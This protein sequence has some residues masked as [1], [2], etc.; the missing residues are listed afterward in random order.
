[1]IKKLLAI[2]FAAALPVLAKTPGEVL[3]DM[4]IAMSEHF[5]V[6]YNCNFRYKSLSKDDT[7]SFTCVAAM[8]RDSKDTIIG[9][10]LGYATNNPD[11]LGVIRI[12]DLLNIYK[13][14]PQTKSAIKYFPHKGQ[15]WALMPTNSSYCIYTEFYHPESIVK[16]SDLKAELLSDT[17]IGGENCYHLMFHG[18]TTAGDL[19]NH[20]CVSKNTHFPVLIQN[21]VSVDGLH[22]IKELY[23]TEVQYDKITDKDFD[24]SVQLSDCVIKDYDEKQ[25]PDTKPALLSVGTKAPEI[26]GKNYQ[27]AISTKINFHGKI[28]LL[29]FWYMNCPWCVKAFPEV[30]KLLDK[31]PRDKF[32]IVGINS[33]DNNEKGLIRLPKFLKRIPMRYETVL[34]PSSLPDAYHISGWPTFYII[35]E[36]GNVAGTY[37]GYEEDMEKSLTEMIKKLLK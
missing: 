31:F 33:R 18:T 13:A 32:Q 11:E 28:T 35:D 20:L 21:Y 25:S 9:G 23:F 34:V 17:V 30:E 36:S 24:P 29:D 1:M 37:L 10:K 15:D 4:K 8:L 19:E 6:S 26:E 16:P 5:S 22:S 2:L 14:D 27:Q 7:I 12:Y 3:N